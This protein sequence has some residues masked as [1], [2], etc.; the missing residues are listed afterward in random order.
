MSEERGRNHKGKAL[1]PDSYQR[2]VS[3]LISEAF[4]REGV[5]E[6]AKRRV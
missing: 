4:N 3:W 2:L 6:Q 5:S 1:H